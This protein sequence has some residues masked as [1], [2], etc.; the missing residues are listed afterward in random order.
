MQLI[1]LDSRVPMLAGDV[2]RE[3]M[4]AMVGVFGTLWGGLLAGALEGAAIVTTH[5]SPQ[6]SSPAKGVTYR[7]IRVCEC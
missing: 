5:W 2:G 7:S 4:L 6:A 3:E 1:G